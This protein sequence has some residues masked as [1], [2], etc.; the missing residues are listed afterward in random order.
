MDL[1]V[2]RAIEF[3]ELIKCAGDGCVFR[4]VYNDRDVAV[5]VVKGEAAIREYEIQKS[6]YELAY[7]RAIE[8]IA[9]IQGLARLSVA[10]IMAISPYFI[11]SI[12]DQKKGLISRDEDVSGLYC[13]VMELG[14]SYMEIEESKRPTATEVIESLLVIHDKTRSIEFLHNDIKL[15]NVVFKSM[16]DDSL[17]AVLIDFARSQ[18]TT[19]PLSEHPLTS[20]FSLLNYQNSFET[21]PEGNAFYTL[22][23]LEAIPSKDA[24]RNFTSALSG[25]YYEDIF[26]EQR[27]SKTIKGDIFS[28]AILWITLLTQS[29]YKTFIDFDNTFELIWEQLENLKK[30]SLVDGTFGYKIFN[31]LFKQAKKQVTMNDFG[32]QFLVLVSKI[33][34]I[35]RLIKYDEKHKK[36]HTKTAIGEILYAMLAFGLVDGFYDLYEVAHYE[37]LSK[38]YDYQ[39]EVISSFFVFYLL[40]GKQLDH[41]FLDSMRR[42][43]R[44]WGATK[45]DILTAS[46]EHIPGAIIKLK[47][48]IQFLPFKRPFPAEILPLIPQSSWCSI[49]ASLEAT[50]YCTQCLQKFCFQCRK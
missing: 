50:Q 20:R 21:P 11:S 28:L 22:M 48:M 13:I 44:E 17:K 40:T 5:K 31:Y 37:W 32:L 38:T 6:V 35:G 30:R 39:N 9:L 47:Q 12:E 18:T 14:L 8:P 41:S 24:T 42:L 33:F 45:N 27:N 10:E 34:D 46:L 23:Q 7:P 3:G 36:E 2:F 15:G 1:T 26:N 19:Y 49:C 43:L 4:A 16:G 29:S 25:F